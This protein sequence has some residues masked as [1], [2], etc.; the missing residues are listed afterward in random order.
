MCRDAHSVPL[1]HTFWVR[2]V[3]LL[4]N[5]PRYASLSRPAI[6]TNMRPRR[7]RQFALCCKQPTNTYPRPRHHLVG[8]CLQAIRPQ[9]NTLRLQASSHKRSKPKDQKIRAMPQKPKHCLVGGCLQAM[10]ALAQHSLSGKQAPTVV[11]M[12][13]CAPHKLVADDRPL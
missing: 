5:R 10:P 9:L 13:Y 6:L 12:L 1:A 4:I 3:S 2:R 11:A 7:Q 8:S